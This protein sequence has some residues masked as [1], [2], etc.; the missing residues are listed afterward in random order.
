LFPYSRS[1]MPTSKLPTEMW[2]HILSYCDHP[3]HCALSMVCR[4]FAEIID[5]RYEFIL[6]RCRRQGVTL[7]SNELLHLSFT[8]AQFP[9][10][11][12]V[13]LPTC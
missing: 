11:L 5:E 10:D 7:P 12:T 8:H 9:L 3:T 4:K 13:N 2:Q 6:G 1:T